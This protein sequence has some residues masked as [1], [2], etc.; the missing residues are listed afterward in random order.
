MQEYVCVEGIS[1]LHA[2]DVINRCGI[3][4][5]LEKVV[6]V[7]KIAE[8]V[9]LVKVKWKGAILLNDNFN[10][11]KIAVSIFTIRNDET[12]I[13]TITSTKRNMFL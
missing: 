10:Y 1:L 6:K 9:K 13:T 2:C 7:V 12:I 4:I 8:L 11:P 3:R 5:N